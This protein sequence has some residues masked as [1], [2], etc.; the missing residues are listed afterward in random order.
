MSK[1]W[2][3]DIEVF[4][5]FLSVSFLNVETEEV[6]QFVVASGRDERREL[7][8][9]IN[10]QCNRLIGF[11]SLSFDDPILIVFLRAIRQTNLN[12]VLYNLSGR[13]IAEGNQ[14]DE[15]IREV[16]WA[17]RSWKS[18][19]L[20]KIMAFDQRGV[21]LKQTAI[22][23][24]WPLIQD[25]PLPYNE[26]VKEEDYQMVLDYNL[27]DV[28]ITFK[29]Y[30]HISKLRQLR[31]EISKLYHVDVTNAS[32]SKMANILLE[33]FYSEAT[34]IKVRDL[35]DL[36]TSRDK[37]SIN[38]CIP[39]NVELGHSVLHDLVE[40][41][42]DVIV[43]VENKF[44][45]AQDI[46]F[47]NKNY[48]LGI[49]GLHSVDTPAKYFSDD[50]YTLIDVDVASY[51]PSMMINLGIKPEHL[52]DKF[53]D[54]LKMIR[55]ER[56][57]A[58]HQGNKTK[59]E[60]LKITIN[61]IYGKLGSN[62]FWLYDPKAM[63]K[64]T[65]AGQLYL[66]M[67]IEAI[68]DGGIE[69][70]SANTDSILCRV[71]KDRVERF[72]YECKKWQERLNLELEFTEYAKIIKS[73]VNNYIAQRKDGT[74][75]EKGIYDTELNLEKMNNHPVIARALRWYFI[76][77]VSIED[78]LM[79]AQNIL[80]FTMSQKTGNA[81][82]SEYVT[83]KGSEPLQ[84]TVRFYASNLGGVLVKRNLLTNKQ[85][86]ILAGQNV[87]VLNDQ[88]PN[89]TIDQYDIDYDWYTKE[90]YKVIDN[91]EPRFV[92]LSFM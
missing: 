13:L 55:D 74:I 36:R 7:A 66:L 46:W 82:Q 44:S 33:K 75:K 58:K 8:N 1:E 89:K 34:G 22:N 32:K 91:I 53:L 9:F 43:K 14:W 3:Y 30:K 52:N 83:R 77:N 5:N 69:V 23:L 50:D 27:N 2:V 29:L 85:I 38:E 11:N 79:S 45:Y 24:G 61:S 28:G 78:T 65:I 31:E 60:A 92:Q 90:I 80:D 48:Q 54:I 51:Y 59:A 39:D 40:D 67:L 26:A 41:L 17:D 76:N 19:D 73:D 18:V 86:G 21:S 70:L 49:G 62:T 37:I 15:K 63:L 12:T 25:L 16:R 68:E 10:T 47:S 56:I 42:R 81:F 4:N 6:V 72:N 87:R 88:D 84:K 20:L 35:R 64:V 57:E 71:P